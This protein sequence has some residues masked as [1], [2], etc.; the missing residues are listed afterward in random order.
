MA[1][2]VLKGLT[3]EIGGDTTK[4]S[5]ALDDVDKK[6]RNLSSELGEINRLLKL[7]PKNT[8]LLAQKQK[9]L[10]DAVS[11]TGKKLDTLKEAEKQVQKQFEKG[12][13][14]AEQVRALQREIIATEKKLQ[15][16]K[17]AA[18]DAGKATEEMDDSIDGLVKGGLTALV[19]AATA[20]IASVV[21]LAEESRE[22][23]A[24]MGKLET[25]YA[26]ANHSADTARA[27]YEELQSVIGETDQSVEAAQQI[28]LLAKSEQDAAKW[29]S[30]AAGVVGRFGDALQPETF[31][32]A[33]NETIKLGEATGAYTQLLEGCGESVEKFNEGLAACNTEEEKQAFMLKVTD[34]L[35]GSAA[36]Q[37]KKTNA[38]VIRSNKATEKWNQATAKLG[39]TVEP[40]MTD[41]KELGVTVLEDFEG[42]LEETADFIR[43]DV[44]PA[45]QGLSNWTRQNLP[46]I[47]AGLTGAAAA[48]VA[49]KVA[50]VTATIAQNGLKGTIMATT[51]AQK[52]L[53]IAQAATPWGLALTAIAAVTAGVVAYTAAT[54]KAKQ[55]VDILT[56]EERELMKAADEAAEA[57]REQKKATDDAR[58]GITSQMKYVGDLAEELKGLANASG[59]VKKKDQARAQFILN[60]LNNALGTEYKMVDGVIQKYNELESSI[61]NVI[62]TK[63]ANALLEASSEAYTAAVQEEA[64]AMEN[65]SLK[66]QDYQHQLEVTNKA[67]ETYEQAYAEHKANIGKMT[68]DQ[69]KMSSLH[70]GSLDQDLK[71]EEEILAEKK[72]AYEDSAGH[73]GQ[74]YNT[75]AT[76]EDAQAAILEGNYQKAVDILSKKG[77]AYG[78]YSDKVDTETAKVLDTLYKE[79]I[80]AGLKAKLTKANFEKGVDGYTKEMVDEADKGY[81]DAMDA[82]STAYADAEAVGGDLG[83]GLNAG[84]EDKRSTLLEKAR[85]LVS[86]IIGAMRDEA[87]SNSPAKKTIEFG[88]D[89]G[90]GAVI[91]VE[92]KTKD[93]KRAGTRQ[94]AALMDAYREQEVGAQKALRHVAEQQTARQATVQRVAASTNSPVLEKIL[95]AIEKGQILTIDGDALVGAT[96]DRM[97]NA[98]GRRRTLATRG[99][100]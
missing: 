51:V 23:R 52:A 10:A 76:Y 13:A 62:R 17:D 69:L 42:P 84:M 20:A 39:K 99:A 8:E 15:G 43:S 36:D 22:Y 59:E 1:N 18:Q 100:I 44:I 33:A 90:E 41:I 28:A 7:D 54:K 80:D 5:K 94:A 87:D 77:G 9:V 4:L 66:Q 63:K 78:N 85:S 83:D 46:A 81:K 73:Y 19:G 3:V 24:E 60:E 75:I 21:A 93:V 70:I 48:I 40:V 89:V 86:G 26:S 11:N 30:L 47:K 53:A 79:A 2:K 68:L 50:S 72:T 55:P 74:V 29:A 92:N 91:G 37:Y 57:F 16:Y 45:I 38:E 6:G 65:L 96:A 27:T 32:E 98:L 97:D 71:R 88:E 64:T 34:K 67:R 25:A 31:F 49:L 56:K 35:L 95:T 61:Q 58:K 14:S 12:D 82:F